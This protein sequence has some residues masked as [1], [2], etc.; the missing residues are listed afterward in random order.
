[1]RGVAGYQRH[2]VHGCLIWNDRYRL[3]DIDDADSEERRCAAPP[4]LQLQ[5]HYWLLHSFVWQRNRQLGLPVIEKIIA[6]LLKM[7]IRLGHLV[8]EEGVR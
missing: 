5:Y 8:E 2:I 7:L 1:M 3:I 4:G 6:R